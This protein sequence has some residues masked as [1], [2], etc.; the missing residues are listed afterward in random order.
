M[1]KSVPDD[2]QVHIGIT[3]NKDV[4]HRLHGRPGNSGILSLELCRETAENA[5]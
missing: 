2:I 3:M 5:A 4:A 1:H